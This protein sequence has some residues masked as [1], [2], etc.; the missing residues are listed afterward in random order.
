MTLGH[1]FSATNSTG[2]VFNDYLY[3]SFMS[4]TALG[5]GNITPITLISR[6]LTMLE[7]MVGI[8]WMTIVLAATLGY[9]Q[10]K[11]NEIAI[12]HKSGL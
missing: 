1:Q 9:A 12:K 5:D 8:I 6:W 7:V 2:I 11:F 3:Y 4:I 10:E